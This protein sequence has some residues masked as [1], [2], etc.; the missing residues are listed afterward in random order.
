[1]LPLPLTVL[2][3]VLNFGFV[4]RAG[5]NV[6]DYVHFYVMR[7]IYLSEIS[8][9]STG[10]PR[11]M[12]VNWG[13]L[14]PMV[15]HGVAFDESDELALPARERSEAWKKRAQRTDAE[16]VYAHTPVGGHFYLVSLDC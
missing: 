14:L 13:G 10:E 8:R 16:C 2:V 15:S 5:Q 4:W 7:P 12:V 9:L 11:L 3:A 1:M 6:G